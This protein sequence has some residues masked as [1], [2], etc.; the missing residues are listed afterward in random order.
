MSHPQADYPHYK[1]NVSHLKMI[2]V[3]RI[4]D[5]YNVKDQA[6]GHAIKKLLCAGDRGGKDFNQD[7]KEAFD[8]LKRKLEMIEEDKPSEVSVSKI[9]SEDIDSTRVENL[10][11]N[12]VVGMASAGGKFTPFK[13]FN[14]LTG[15]KK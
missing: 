7:I 8:T 2:D 1:K 14:P 13:F 9:R 5:L 10:N 11:G 4:L 12:M 6:V 15:M 3:Y